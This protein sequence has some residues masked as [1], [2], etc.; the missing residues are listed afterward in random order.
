MDNDEMNPTDWES[1]CD[2]PRA[3]MPNVSQISLQLRTN[4][5]SFVLHSSIS[6]S[7]LRQEIS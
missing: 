1:V 2:H 5:R 7:Q 4:V 3:D 6:T